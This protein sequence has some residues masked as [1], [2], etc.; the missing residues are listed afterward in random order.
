MDMMIRERVAPEGPAEVA[1]RP[2]RKKRWIRHL[3]GPLSEPAWV[4]PSVLAL[5]SVTGLMFLWGLGASGWANGYYSAAVQAATKSWKAL[6][7]GS[8]D[9]SNFIT[10]DKTP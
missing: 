5:L 1:A 9:S 10:V 3:R 4:R 2:D 7:F 6:L 8:L